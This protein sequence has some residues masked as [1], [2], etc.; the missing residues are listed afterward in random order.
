MKSVV[1]EAST[2][3]KAIEQGWKSAGEPREFSIKI[4]EIPQYNFLGFATRSAKVAIIFEEHA[5]RE[6]SRREKRDGRDRDQRTREPRRD[7][8]DRDTRERSKSET[9]PRVERSSR[10]RTS[11]EDSSRENTRTRDR[12]ERPRDRDEMREQ[13]DSGREINRQS[14]YTQPPTSTESITEMVAVE[15]RNIVT[16]PPSIVAEALAPQTKSAEKPLGQWDDA[17]VM[18]AQNWLTETLKLMNLSDVTF[19]VEPQNFHLRITLSKP[20]IDDE[21]KEKHLFSSLSTLMIAS[22]KKEYRKALRGHKIVIV[23]G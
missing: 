10:E 11:R 2:I 12:R 22:L 13:R 5:P 7:G 8:R 18:S 21:T 3:G 4:L 1:Q 23:H 9:S 20:I 19:T 16:P 6:E 15:K 17:L 14:R